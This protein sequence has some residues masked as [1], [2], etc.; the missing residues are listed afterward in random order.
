MKFERIHEI[1]AVSFTLFESD[2]DE[3]FPRIW[4]SA[5]WRKNCFLHVRVY[6]P[7]CDGSAPLP[8]SPLHYP[9]AHLMTGEVST[10]GNVGVLPRDRV[11]RMLAFETPDCVPLEYHPSPAGF[12]EHGT[13][14]A[15]LWARFPDDFGP[16]NRF[17]I[18]KPAG[19]FDAH[20]RYSEIRTDDWGVV[21]RHKVFG[22]VG[23]PTIRPLDDWSRLD[24]FRPPPLPLPSGAVFDEE[25]RRAADHR[26]EYFLK[27]GWISLFEQM[28]AL[29][30]FEE[31][32][33]DIAT[34]SV[35]INRLADLLT[36]YHARNINYLIERGV[37]AIQFG[38]DFGTQSGLL[39]SPRHWR[40]FFKPR[41]EY[42][43]RLIHRAGKK[44]F[45]HTCGCV[46][47]LLD[48]LAD[49]KVDAIWPQL[50]TYDHAAL[51]RFCAESRVA[52]ALHPD[53]GHIMIESSPQAV[54]DHVAQLAERFQVDRGGAWFYLEIDS[55][56]P[57]ENV[58]AV[59]ETIGAMR[60]RPA[61]S[62]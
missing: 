24:G 39:L 30:S 10:T 58:V 20:G 45:F 37:D 35:E 31:V 21:W 12:Y 23:I 3:A 28:H 27:S 13:K 44:V 50:N 17:D 15:E 34:G 41:Y 29:R 5:K 55:G 61:T 51:A 53:R 42:L 46:R 48:E 38:D 54:R 14:L 19:T 52:I 11:L 18:P 62:E 1:G 32:L 57:W 40:A 43:C 33:P 49:L 25:R 56:F 36:E 26:R 60:R 2:V 9:K 8:G 6:F 47:A 16:V 4:G 22:A 59:T 7:L